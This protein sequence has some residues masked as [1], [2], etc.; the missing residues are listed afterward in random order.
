MQTY[1]RPLALLLIV[2]LLLPS[3]GNV[4]AAGGAGARERYDHILV[5]DTLEYGYIVSQSA[6]GRQSAH[7]LSFQPGADIRPLVSAGG[8]VFGA[9]NINSVIAHVERQ[10]HNVLGGI[11]ADFFSFQTGVPE[12]IY[13]SSGELRSSHQ[14]RGAVFFRDDGSA[15]LGNPSLSFSLLNQNV[16]QRVDISFFNKFRQPGWLFLFDEHFSTTTRTTTPGREVLFRITGGSVTVGGEVSLEV[17]G[18]QDSAGATPIPAG[19]MVLSADLLSP[20]LYHLDRFALGDRVT[21][22]VGASDPRIRQAAW[23]TGGGDILISGGSR[24]PSSGWDSGVAGVHP[25]SALGIRADGSLLL[26][27]VDGRLPGHSAGLTLGELA[28]EMLALGAVYAIN[29]DG[30]GSTSFSYR[31]PGTSSAAVLN[32]PSGNALRNC[33]TFILLTATYGRGG[34]AV[35]IQFHP[36]HA[37]ILGGSLI[38]PAELANQITMTDRGYFPLDPAGLRFAALT[39]PTLGQQEGDSFRT[40]ITNASGLLTTHGA[41]GAVGRLRLDL[42]SRPDR[43]DL[44]LA[45]QLV[46]SLTLTAG[47][48][49]R[50][51]HHFLAA[52]R[53]L[54]ASPDVYSITVSSH[55]AT[56]N[57]GLL[58]ITGEPGTAGQISISAGGVTRTIPLSIAAVFPDTI[59]HWA[60]GYIGQMRAAGVLTGISTEQGTFFFPNRNVTRAEFAAMFTRLLGLDTSQYALTGQEFLD[61][62][63]IPI[64]ARPYVAAMFQNGYIAG[65]AVDGGVLFDAASPITRAEA[66]TILGRLMDFTAP[67]SVLHRFT[68]HADIPAWARA[69][70]ARLVYLG[71]LTGTDDGRLLPQNNLSR[72]EAAAILARLNLTA[73]LAAA[74]ED[75]L[76]LPPEEE[77]SL[78]EPDPNL[79]EPDSD[80]DE[81][82][83]SD[84]EADPESDTESDPESDLSG[85]NPLRRTA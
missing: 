59:G 27:A 35:N 60:E 36:G 72:A 10:G 66:F 25:R 73:L 45:G 43:I 84:P 54:I 44:R 31:M 76:A 17:V 11:N 14:G 71:L 83:L 63:A 22:R 28:D 8:Q 32:R 79:P 12:G 75:P 47:D 15:F 49:V 18:I 9:S 57:A 3:Q 24:T 42:F 37:A 77:D 13:I 38:S 40:A 64:W 81:E 16:G 26:Y 19:H 50:L 65:R 6:H 29:L 21:L 62:A 58:T 82:D 30:G 46:D 70:I 20:Y 74:E 7:Y 51:S 53:D 67:D 39:A 41:N 78:P 23:A 80:P 85:E 55:I 56:L 4:L 5:S 48:Q 52:G 33:A 61:H 1:K 69:E 68:D 34:E 2:L